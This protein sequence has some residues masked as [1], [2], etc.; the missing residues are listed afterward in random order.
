MFTVFTVSEVLI[1]HVLDVLM[2]L[3]ATLDFSHPCP[4]YSCLLSVIAL[5]SQLPLL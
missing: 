5:A 1:F 4:I 3:P 2:D